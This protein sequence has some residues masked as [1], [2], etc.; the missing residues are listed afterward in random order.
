[1]NPKLYEYRGRYRTRRELALLAGVT[2]EA[3]RGR[4]ERAGMAVE[5]AVGHRFRSHHRP[6]GQTPST[7]RFR[8]ELRTIKQ[9]AELTGRSQTWVREN[10]V[11]GSVVEPDRNPRGKREHDQ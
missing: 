2:P 1:M 8:G 11:N 6:H 5:A 7:Y 4:I 10:R 9:I 3:I